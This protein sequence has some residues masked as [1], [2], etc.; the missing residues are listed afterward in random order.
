[1]IDFTRTQHHPEISLD[2]A[3]GI[4]PHFWDPADP[5]KAIEQHDTLRPPGGPWSDFS[6]KWTYDPATEA[7]QYGDP[8]E[9]DADPALLPLAYAILPLSR[10]RIVVYPHAW[11]MILQDDGSFTIDRRD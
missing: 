5:R 1:M 10:E 4:L 6:S 8:S 9:E 2:E 11:V 3:V 7:V